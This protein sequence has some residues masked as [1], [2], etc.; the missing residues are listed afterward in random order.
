VTDSWT[1]SGDDLVRGKEYRKF[2]GQTGGEKKRPSTPSTNQKHDCYEGSH[3]S[4][5]KRVSHVSEVT[6]YSV[7]PSSSMSVEPLA[8]VVVPHADGAVLKDMGDQEAQCNENYAH[9]GE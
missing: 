6:R 4:Y 5:F 9:N 7:P 3:A 2:D 1:R 8:N